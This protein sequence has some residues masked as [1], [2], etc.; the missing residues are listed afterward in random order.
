[1]LGDLIAHAVGADGDGAVRLL[2]D[3]GAAAQADGHHVGHP[4]VGAH[5]ADGGRHAGLSGEPILDDP[6]VGGGAAYV[7]DDGILQLAQ[8]AC[9]SDGV[10]GAAGDG[11]DGVAAGVLHGHE[12]AVVLGQVHVRVGDAL[13]FQALGEPFG[14]PLRHLPQGGVQD[15][16]VLSFNQ[17]HGA[18]LT[19]DGHV[20]VLPH[21]F[22]AQLRRTQFVVVPDG[23]E[24]AGDGDGLDALG[25]HVQVERLGRRLIQG[26]QLLAVVLKAA[27][28]DGAAHGDALDV[29]RPIH[30]GQDAG[31]S[32]R[33]NAQDADGRQVLALYDGVGTLG[34]AQHG[35]VDLRAVN[36]GLLQHSANS[37]Q[38]PVIDIAGGGVLDVRHNVQVFVD[39]D[40]VGVGAAYVNAQLIHDRSLP[41][42]VLPTGYNRCRSQNTGGR[43][44]RCPP[45]C[46]TSR[47]TSDPP[48]TRACHISGR[49]WSP[50]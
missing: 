8:V 41:C 32:R 1:M 7:D 16:G 26:S 21:H 24:H 29:L 42:T 19:G 46:A 17:T 11:Q 33:A 10:G 49:R 40:G 6:Q 13:P 15:G 30:H 36:A 27:A 18:D 5:A 22:L 45:E 38:D 50:G 48:P 31:G 2:P 44:G 14:E 37:A 43:P 28:D 35:L 39:E 3:D 34:S 20:D 47:S 23:G 12:G 4:E 9:P 25:L